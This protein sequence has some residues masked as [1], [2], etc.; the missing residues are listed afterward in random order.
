MAWEQAVIGASAA[1]LVFVLSEW[2]KTVRDVRSARRETARTAAALY[3]EMAAAMAELGP[4]FADD[5]ETW[6]LGDGGPP[7]RLR[8]AAQ[9]FAELDHETLPPGFNVIADQTNQLT[10]NYLHFYDFCVSARLH[11]AGQSSRRRYEYRQIDFEQHSEQNR[12]IRL[13]RLRYA[14]GGVRRRLAR[15]HEIVAALLRVRLSS[16]RRSQAAHALHAV[17]ARVPEPFRLHQ[18]HDR[19][20]WSDPVTV[21]MWRAQTRGYTDQAWWLEQAAELLDRWRRDRWYRACR[22]QKPPELYP[23][24]MGYP[25]SPA[26]QSRSGMSSLGTLSAPPP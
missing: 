16:K 26:G 24:Y 7:E 2:R 13:R 6:R 19:L 9:R 21:P 8:A 25:V 5:V 3:R 12:I 23:D 15:L 17:Q 18:A 10:T 4:G 20:R 14:L 11:P 1:I 22:M